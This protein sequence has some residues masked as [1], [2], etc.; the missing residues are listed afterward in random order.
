MD[1]KK[2]KQV[3]I[4]TAGLGAL[5]V[6]VGAFGAH[7]LK[8]HLNADQLL[9]YE[10]GVRYLFIHLLASLFVCSLSMQ[11]KLENLLW[12]AK[13][14]IVG[15]ILFSFSIFFL[16]TRSIFGLEEIVWVGPI[17]PIG[18]LI[19]IAGWLILAITLF[20]KL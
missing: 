10:T 18:G 7:Y 19:L 2:H 3:L 11:L 9:S 16:S 6:I 14:F 20:R 17:T 5:T 13:L 15:A 12:S 4:I 1:T 8:E